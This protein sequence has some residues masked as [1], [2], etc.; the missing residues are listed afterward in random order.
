MLVLATV[1]ELEIIGEAA[2][3]ISQETKV[4]YPNIPWLDIIGMSHRLI[5]AYFVI[6]IGVI[7]QTITHDIPPIIALLNSTI[8]KSDT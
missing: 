6:D 3:K 8:A 1:K 5:H 2:S 4:L 7:W